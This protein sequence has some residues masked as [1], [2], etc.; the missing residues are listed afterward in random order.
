MKTAF[1]IFRKHWKNHKSD[2]EL[3][4]S[5]EDQNMIESAMEEYANQFKDQL[6]SFEKRAMSEAMDECLALSPK[7]RTISPKDQPKGGE[8]E[9]VFRRVSVKERLPEEMNDPKWKGYTRGVYAIHANGKKSTGYFNIN[10]GS[11]FDKNNIEA[12][13]YEM[14]IYWLEEVSLPSSKGGELPSDDEIEERCHELFCVTEMTEYQKGRK[15]GTFEGMKLMRDNST[16]PSKSLGVEGLLKWIDENKCPDVDGD[17]FNTGND[18]VIVEELL[19]Q[20]HKT[21]KP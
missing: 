3:L 10:S 13:E 18:I 17:G 9:T 12:D 4:L 5:T 19:E 2:K 8:S 21:N 20:I 15:Q 1:E 6:T 11:F 14:P 7:E 16:P